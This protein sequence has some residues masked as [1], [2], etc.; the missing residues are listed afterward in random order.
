MLESKVVQLK[1]D[2]NPFAGTGFKLAAEPGAAPIV[3][4]S[5]LYFFVFLIEYFSIANLRMQ[6]KQD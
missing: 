5:F 2:V 1:V 3:R 4:D 6:E